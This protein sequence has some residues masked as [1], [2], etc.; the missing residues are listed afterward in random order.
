VVSRVSQKRRPGQP[1]PRP[2]ARARKAS[3]VAAW[4]AVVATL[5][6][7][8]WVLTIPTRSTGPAPARPGGPQAPA[9]KA[10]AKRV[11]REVAPVAAAG[12]PFTVELM[13]PPATGY[14][15]AAPVGSET[16]YAA[17]VAGLR[18]PGVLY[19]PALSRA[20]RELALQQSLLG[21]LVPQ[22]IVDFL[23]R[24]AGAVDRTV[25]Q[26][27]TATSG[28]GT[29]AARQRVEDL[30]GRDPAPG[31]VRIGIGEVWI[32]GAALP[33]IVGVLLS[34][35]EVE[36]SAAPRRLEAGETWEISG[37]LPRGD[38]DP[39]AM[40]LRPDGQLEEVPVRT[41]DRR[42]QLDVAA[43][44][45]AGTLVVNVGANSRFGHTTLLQVP[46]EVGQPLPATYETHLPPD[47][48]RLRT[49]EAAEPVAFALLNADRARF[50]LPAL[51]RDARLDAVARAHS[52][53][54]REHGFFGH[55]SPTTGNPQDR[56]TA[57]GYRFTRCAE[58]IATEQSVHAAEA[59]LFASL[60]H[61][62][63]ILSADVTHVGIG[64]AAR[65]SSNHVEWHL[66]Q[67]FARPAEGE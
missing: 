63:N 48:S 26:S 35:R 44:D 8:A 32:P 22:D 37:V 38:Q 61:R 62:R 14:A 21:G 65:V 7:A 10:A 31:P 50:G 67:L 4:L 41:V 64:I 36:V 1:P 58:N 46:V 60:G 42:F 25:V 40:V 15:A 23:L 29:E 66:T 30:L 13:D 6:L 59:N 33:R 3:P 12:E 5:A 11:L 2:P 19:D 43:G 45:T 27:Y 47:E 9:P 24:S 55:R 49:A 52:T 18:R 34:R 53:D 28:D 54:M 20:A 39:S 57:A 17:L 51:V 16:G 56:I